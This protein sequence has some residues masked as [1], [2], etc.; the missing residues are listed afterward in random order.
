MTRYNTMQKNDSRITYD[1]FFSVFGLEYPVCNGKKIDG[2]ALNF[3]YRYFAKENENEEI[4][5]PGD[6][7]VQPEIFYNCSYDVEHGYLMTLLEK[8]LTESAY[9]RVEYVPDDANIWYEEDGEPDSI[10]F[11]EAIEIL[12]KYPIAFD[13]SDNIETQNLA[14]C[15][16]KV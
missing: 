14:Y 1:Q 9:S 8:K 7:S 5:F 15:M 3:Q 2:L 13:N 16:T 12:K 10:S 4:L 11:S 6:G